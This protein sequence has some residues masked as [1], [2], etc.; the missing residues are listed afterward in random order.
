MCVH[1]PKGCGCVAEGAPADLKAEVGDE[2][3]ELT[4]DDPAAMQADLKAKFDLEATVLDRTLRVQSAGV[5]R[6]MGD[7]VDAYGDRVE[8]VAFSHPSLEDVY[9]QKTGH[10]FWADGEAQG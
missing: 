1:S 9:I 2:L 6:L 3:L 4:C 7:L 8:R 5:H 10:R